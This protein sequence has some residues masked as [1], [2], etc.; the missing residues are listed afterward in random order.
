M[1]LDEYKK[2]LIERE[3]ILKKNNKNHNAI[4]IKKNGDPATQDK[5]NYWIRKWG[6]FL[7]NDTK[8]NPK[9]EEIP[10][11][12]HMFRHALCTK[13]A[14]QGIG[15]D[16]IVAIFG[17]KTADMYNIYCDIDEDERTFKDIDKLDHIF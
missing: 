8:T 14:R 1:F 4:F 6:E 12:C 17:W 13:L 9:H 15:Q 2:W 16:L 3:E 10:A 7:T 5:V 11:Y